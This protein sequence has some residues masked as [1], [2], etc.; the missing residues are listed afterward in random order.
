[1]FQALTILENSHN[2]LSQGFTDYAEVGLLCLA[3]P[4]VPGITLK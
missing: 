3:W 1:M 4:G 2:I